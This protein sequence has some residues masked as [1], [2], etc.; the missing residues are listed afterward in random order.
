LANIFTEEKK[1]PE[2]FSPKNAEMS[3]REVYGSVS[4]K[5]QRENN[6]VE[7]IQGVVTTPTL[8]IRRLIYQPSVIGYGEWFVCGWNLTILF[9]SIKVSIGIRKKELEY[10]LFKLNYAKRSKINNT[11]T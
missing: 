2:N 3:S 6:G 9:L 8:V 10:T 11:W 7:K 1:I 5:K 4:E